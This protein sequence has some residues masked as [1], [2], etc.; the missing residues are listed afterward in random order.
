M[1]YGVVRP[2]DPLRRRLPALEVAVMICWMED[3][4]H[5]AYVR[6]WKAAGLA[7]QEIRRREIRATVTPVALQQLSGAF[8]DA[9][10][11]YPP[12]PGSGLVEQQRWFLLLAKR[13]RPG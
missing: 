7:I 9:V 10:H 5:K 12:R 13:V 1:R 11:R 6:G 3:P 2:E 4:R 8:N